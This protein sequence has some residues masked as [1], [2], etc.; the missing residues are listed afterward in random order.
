MELRETRSHIRPILPEDIPSATDLVRRVFQESVAPLYGPEGVREF[1]AYASLE[2][3]T[4]R[5]RENHLAFVA[6]DESRTIVGVVEVRD[7]RHLSLLFVE[8][9]HQKKGI[10]RALIA[11]AIEACRA[12]GPGLRGLTVNASPNSVGA[13]QKTGFVAVEP[14]QEKNGI[15]FV[16]MALTLGEVGDG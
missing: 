5:L 7:H 10:G 8:T 12:A 11:S 1:M 13:Y 14:E 6:E 4:Q 15:R 9:A 3:F 2:P 16:P